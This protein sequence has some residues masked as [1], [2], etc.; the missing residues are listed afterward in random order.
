MWMDGCELQKDIVC[1]SGNRTVPRVHGS[2]DKYVLGS[3]AYINNLIR[4][5]LQNS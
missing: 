2:L 4:S 5:I 1:G 3:P